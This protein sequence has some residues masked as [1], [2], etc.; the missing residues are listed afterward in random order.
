ML[1]THLSGAF[2]T[3]YI[4]KLCDHTTRQVPFSYGE[5]P[6]T[7]SYWDSD[8]G[9]ATHRMMSYRNAD[10]V[11]ICFSVTDAKTFVNAEAVWNREVESNKP[12][13]CQKLLVGTKIDLRPAFSSSHM[14]GPNEGRALAQR[15]GAIGYLECSAKTQEG[16]QAVFAGAHSWGDHKIRQ[17][18]DPYRPL[19]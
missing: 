5:A 11:I 3:G 13:L 6:L 15:I 14:L 12:K 19:S 8:P 10:I 18:K 1:L 16:L 4:Q 2:P 7:V 9:D 17:L